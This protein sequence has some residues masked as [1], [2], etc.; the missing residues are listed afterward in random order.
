MYKIYAVAVGEMDVD[1]HRIIPWPA[2]PGPPIHISFYMWCLKG[3]KNT[4]LVDAGTGGEYAEKRK[5]HGTDYL[6]AQLKK[7][8]VDVAQIDT[9]IMTHLHMDHFSG[10]KLYPKANFWIQRKEIEFLTGPAIRFRQIMELV[11]DMAEVI[12]LAYAKRIR[13]LD[14]DEQ[15]V[16]GIRVVLVGGHTPGSQVVVVTTKEGEA[17]ICSDAVDL[18]RNLEE[19]VVAPG[20]DLLQGLMAW[21][22]IKALASSPKLIIP[23][24]D[25]LVLKK[26]PNPVEGVAEIG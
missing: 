6:K 7:L 21:D 5:F 24:H 25:P 11:P 12:K 3:E 4:I 19:G 1:S 22:K 20:V 16:P 26:F 14:G 10:Y 9:V 2:P 15:I 18:Y 23:S 13:Y 17:V 8:D